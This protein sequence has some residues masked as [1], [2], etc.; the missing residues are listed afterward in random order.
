M[1]TP[2]DRGFGDDCFRRMER[3][4]MAKEAGLPLPDKETDDFEDA[5]VVDGQ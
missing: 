3:R 1:L 5:I 4:K 2:M